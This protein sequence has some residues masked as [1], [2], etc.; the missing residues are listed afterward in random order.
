MVALS[1]LLSALLVGSFIPTVLSEP[2]DTSV[3]ITLHGWGLLSEYDAL[4]NATMR[5]N[6]TRVGTDVRVS[7]NLTFWNATFERQFLFNFS[8]KKFT[9][10]F[11]LLLDGR[12][13]ASTGF[14]GFWDSSNRMLATGV[15]VYR[16]N[17]RTCMYVAGLR[18][19]SLPELWVDMYDFEWSGVR[20]IYHTWKFLISHLP[21]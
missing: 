8:G 12:W 9:W 1:V 10:V 16:E 5:I 20:L 17:N 19:E 3:D 6:G 11:F 2:D 7:A 4:F 15:H 18:T 13:H 14:L 21:E